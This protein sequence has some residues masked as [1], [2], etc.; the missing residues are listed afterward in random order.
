[1]KCHTIVDIVCATYNNRKAQMTTLTMNCRASQAAAPASAERAPG[2]V[3]QDCP[4]ARVVVGPP[5]QHTAETNVVEMRQR[6]QAVLEQV[7]SLCLS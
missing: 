5:L 1:M 6:I 3:A 4:A 2:P 7:G